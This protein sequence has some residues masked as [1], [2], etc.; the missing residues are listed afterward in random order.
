MERIR[1]KKE[2]AYNPGDHVSRYIWVFDK[3]KGKA[4]LDASCGEGYGTSWLRK[5]GIDVLG[6]DRSRMAFKSSEKREFLLGD[7]LF[8]PFRSCTFDAI[9]SFEVI[10]HL[11]DGNTYLSQISNLLKSHGIFLGS[12]P[13]RKKEKYLD[14]R[15]K[16]PFHKREYYIDEIKDLLEKYFEKVRI[17]RQIFPSKIKVFFLSQMHRLGIYRD[18]HKSY[19]ILNGISP[20]DEKCLWTAKEPRKCTLE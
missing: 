2:F 18:Q 8:M 16:N 3:T 14:G 17:F 1:A 7:V 5:N 19:P 9:I 6:I 4:T 15:P 20:A 11:E 13:I 10:E 12:T